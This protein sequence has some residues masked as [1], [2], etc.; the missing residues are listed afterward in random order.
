MSYLLRWNLVGLALSSLAVF[1]GCGDSK[2]SASKERAATHV[3]E[4]DRDDH[5][6]DHAHGHGAKG[7][8]GGTI[9]EFGDERYHAELVHDDA[10]HTTTIYL[11]G[12]GAKGAVPVAAEDLKLNLLVAGKPQQFS[13]KAAA[14][15]ADPAGRA[16][17][18]Q[19]ADAALCEALDAKGTT[20]RLNVEIEGKAFVGKL[21]E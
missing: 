12:E 6:H 8:H 7:P 4:S 18:F 5:D 20:G 17:R 16:S 11:L 10:A 21:E 19:S 3:S 13:L 9:I 1:V 15:A 2:S 14:E